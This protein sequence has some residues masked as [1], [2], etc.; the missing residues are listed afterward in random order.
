MF[1]IID[2]IKNNNTAFSFQEK[3]V[4]K[5]VQRP[6]VIL[7]EHWKYRARGGRGGIYMEYGDVWHDVCVLYS[8]MVQNPI[9]I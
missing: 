9:K 7:H 3:T 5:Q 4:Q 2:F 8:R 6:G 1:L